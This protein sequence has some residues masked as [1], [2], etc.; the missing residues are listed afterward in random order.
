MLKV[1]NYLNKFFFKYGS[2]V[3]YDNS[4]TFVLL[5]REEA[6]KLIPNNYYKQITIVDNE[7]Q[8][9][10]NIKLSEYFDSD[11]FLKTNES[12]LVIEYNKD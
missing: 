7:K 6:K 5:S 1:P 12:K 3:F 4:K 9:T 10:K 2:D 8:K 11:L